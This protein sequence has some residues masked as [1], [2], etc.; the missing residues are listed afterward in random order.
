MNTIY[1]FA[2]AAV[3]TAALT[4]CTSAQG[5][6]D[7]QPALQSQSSP[8]V[9]ALPTTPI[10]IG[11]DTVGTASAMNARLAAPTPAIRSASS[12]WIGGAKVVQPVLPLAIQP[13][14]RLSQ[15]LALWLKTQDINL[16]WEPA[17][18]LPGR[19]RDVVIES[20]WLASQAALEPTLSEVLA[21]FGLSA[22]VLRQDTAPTLGSSGTPGLPP[23]SVVVRNASNSRP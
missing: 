9:L 18:S 13:G 5:F 10:P 6:V 21:P 22:H 16:S 4:A 2:I 20:A 17:G 15:A 11:P 3:S 8:A 7:K 14:Q 1:K 19:V 23:T 12:P